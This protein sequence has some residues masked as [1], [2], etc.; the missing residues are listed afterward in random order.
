MYG[1][2]S[3]LQVMDLSL[4]GNFGVLEYDE[5]A[6]GVQTPY[7][8]FGKPHAWFA[9]HRE[10]SNYCSMNHLLWGDDKLW[11][12]IDPK[13]N[14]KFKSFIGEQYPE[15]CD[16]YPNC[17]TPWQHKHLMFD[18]TLLL[19][20]GIKVMFIRQKPGDIVITPANGFHGGWNTGQN[21]AE[22]ANFMLNLKRDWD[23]LINAMELTVS[24]KCYKNCYEHAFLDAYLFAER[25]RKSKHIIDKQH[26]PITGDTKYEKMDKYKYKV[27]D[28]IIDISMDDKC[29]RPIIIG[30]LKLAQKFYET[31]HKKQFVRFS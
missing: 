8:Y 2:D 4:F 31:Y 28:S 15:Y 16:Y 27:C 22:S 10:D 18:P 24:G 1:P 17:K 3:P 9:F 29:D 30:T 5:Y 20:K 19:S 12:C 13:D 6:E 23:L 11:F 26:I 14:Q 7:I 25:C 21:M